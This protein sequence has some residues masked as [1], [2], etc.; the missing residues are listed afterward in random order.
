MKM[1]DS[2]I[3][4]EVSYVQSVLGTRRIGFKTTTTRAVAK[5]LL[6]GGWFFSGGY[7]CYPCAKSI[8]CGVYEVFLKEPPK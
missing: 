7:C 3:K 4:A 5:A 8:G 1:T 6:L 2:Q